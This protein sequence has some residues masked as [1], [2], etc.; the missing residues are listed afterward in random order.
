MYNSGNITKIFVTLVLITTSFSG[1]LKYY[2][3]PKTEIPQGQEQKY[4]QRAVEDDIKSVAVYKQVET[5]AFFDVM[6]FSDVVSAAYVDLYCN[7]R[8]MAREAKRS[9]EDDFFNANSDKTVFCVLADVRKDRYKNLQDEDS[10]WSMFI[11]LKDGTKLVPQKIEKIEL[12]T[13]VKNLFGA[14][15]SKFKKA[16]RVTFEPHTMIKAREFNFVISSVD[17][18]TEITWNEEKQKKSGRHED[19][20]WV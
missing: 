9:F 20:Y 12:D 1:C 4:T 7:R 8:G 3:V 17:K 2:K 16:Y 10:A 6:L 11:N 13:E 15:F 14:K 5:Q 19:Y 18:F